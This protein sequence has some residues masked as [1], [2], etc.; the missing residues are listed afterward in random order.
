MRCLIS[1]T[2]AAA[3]G[4]FTVMRTSSEP[5]RRARCT[6]SPWPA[7]SAVSV[8]RHRLDHDGGA[9]ADLDLADA[10]PEGRV[11]LALFHDHRIYQKDRPGGSAGPAILYALRNLGPGTGARLGPYEIFAA[12]Y[13]LAT[14]YMSAPPE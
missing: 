2:A 13:G 1:G 8:V 10:D 6:A 5:A 12:D 11:A 14:W 9:A 4:M 7:T 3:S